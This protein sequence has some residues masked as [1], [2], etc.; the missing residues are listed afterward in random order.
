MHDFALFLHILGWA[1][2]MGAQTAL[3]GLLRR[4]ALYDQPVG[5]TLAGQLRALWVTLF[6]GGFMAAGAGLWLVFITPP[7]ARMGFVHTKLLLLIFELFVA[8]V[9][10]RAAHQRL[11]EGG[12]PLPGIWFGLSL[13]GFV[14]AIALGVFKPF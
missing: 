11:S 9:P 12:A 7:F 1:Q 5:G 10:L 8:L 3:A 14:A 4:E 2:W 13:A 6:I